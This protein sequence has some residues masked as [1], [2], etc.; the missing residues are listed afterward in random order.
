M[1]R[2]EKKEGAGP[3]SVP[4]AIPDAAGIPRASTL[5]DDLP[6]GREKPREATAHPILGLLKEQGIPFED[7]KQALEEG[8]Y[9]EE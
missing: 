2:T 9:F 3:R 5:P 8:G 6:D 4:V 1:N 7:V